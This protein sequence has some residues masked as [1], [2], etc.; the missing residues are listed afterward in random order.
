MYLKVH[1][2]YLSLSNGGIPMKRRTSIVAL[3]LVMVMLMS[4]CA[5]FGSNANTETTPE[6]SQNEQLQNAAPGV[7]SFT[8]N[9]SWTPVP[10]TKTV[11]ILTIGNG[12]A[13]DGAQYLVPMAREL[14]VEVVL[15]HLLANDATVATFDNNTKGDTAGALIFNFYKFSGDAW[16]V[17]SGYSLK[18]AL[19]DDT[20]DY[21]IFSQ[22]M[23]L[24]G[25]I[26]TIQGSVS[27]NHHLKQVATY[28]NYNMK[29]ASG[30]TYKAKMLWNM[31]WAFEDT[32]TYADFGKYDF[33]QM[34]MYDAIVSTTQT[35]LAN[36]QVKKYVKGVIPTGTAVQNLR[37]SY[38][39]DGITRDGSNL[40]YMGKILSAMMLL[41]SVVDVDINALTFESY[42]ELAFAKPDLAV[43]KEAVNNAYAKPYEVT[44]SAYPST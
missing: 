8:K 18:K 2:A 1:R 29:T 12:Q 42:E 30:T 31:T 14:G 40:S 15:A 32:A 27:E 3:L 20:W 33:D 19:Q 41:R 6:A 24:A 44:Q 38:W 11:K 35:A 13:V 39:F 21:I 9:D 25:D 28:V 4:S 23:G 26:E 5:F 7:S 36:S 34:K 22:T 16:S 43:L 37:T 17:R 10:I